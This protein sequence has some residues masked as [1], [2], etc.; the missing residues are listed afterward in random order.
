M[1]CATPYTVHLDKPKYNHQTHEF[2]E[3]IPV[4]C[5]KCPACKKRRVQEW[6]FRIRQEHKHC[7]TAYFVTLTYNNEHVPRTK[8]GF[9]T[10][11]K[12]DYQDYMKRLRKQTIA[13]NKYVWQKFGYNYNDKIKYYAVGE[14]GD[15]RKRPH[16]HAIIFN[17]NR[18]DIRKTWGKGDVHIDKVNTA[19]IAYTLKYMEK[20]EGKPYKFENCDAVKQFSL[21]SKGLGKQYLTDEIIRYHRN[22]ENSTV[23]IG[24][25]K[26][27]LPRYYQKHLFKD[28]EETQK[29][30]TIHVMNEVKKAQE[31]AEKD[32]E[33][34]NI[35][36]KHYIEHVRNRDISLYNQFLTR[37]G[38]R[39]ID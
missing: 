34:K 33:R 25:A 29:K 37:Q 32:F 39:T 4:P 31:E 2:V 13:T 15:R 5:G 1:P 35:N 8:N 30:Y 28:D 12:K 26:I 6:L 3:T 7:R 11:R 19:T 38:R 14:Y 20:S 9:L 21:M 17:A 24:D 22:I 36:G 16:Y 18:E 10:L 23:K 27:A